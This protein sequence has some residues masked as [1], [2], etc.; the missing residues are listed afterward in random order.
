VCVPAFQHLGNQLLVT[1]E[2]GGLLPYPPFG[3]GMLAVAALVVDQDVPEAVQLAM[4][5][6]EMAAAQ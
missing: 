4:L 1:A 3:F 5:A 6:E 2:Q